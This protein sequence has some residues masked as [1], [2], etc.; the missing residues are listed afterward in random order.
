M[1]IG[2]TEVQAVPS[3]SAEVVQKLLRGE[4]I[5]LTQFVDISRCA[6]TAQSELK[7]PLE[8]VKKIGD[9][10]RYTILFNT[11]SIVTATNR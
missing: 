4:E 11:N 1:N 6:W 2:P 5:P 3:R 7:L 8:E 9:A 10:K